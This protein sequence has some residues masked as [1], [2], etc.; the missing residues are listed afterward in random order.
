MCCRAEIGASAPEG[1][2]G[3]DRRLGKS[4]PQDSAIRHGREAQPVH[5]GEPREAKFNATIQVAVQ[6]GINFFDSSD[7]YWVTRHEVLLERAMK[8]RHKQA[9]I[10]SKF[11]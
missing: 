4:G 8:G 1:A 10:T 9:M 7:A 5:F 3:N 11:G 6:L 2:L